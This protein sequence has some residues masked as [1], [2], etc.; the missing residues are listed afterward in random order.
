[1][2]DKNI[3]IQ[4][5]DKKAILTGTPVIVCGNSDYTLTFTF[6]NEWSEHN[7]KTARFS[8]IKEGERQ[9]TDIV[10]MGNIVTAPVLEKVAF[11]DVGV[12]AGNLRTTTPARILCW[13]SILCDSGVPHEPTP[14]VY[15]Q[16]MALLEEIKRVDEID[17]IYKNTQAIEE[18]QKES[19]DLSQN[20]AEADKVED[21][22]QQIEEIIEH[23]E[24]VVTFPSDGTGERGQFLVSNGDGTASWLTVDNAEGGAY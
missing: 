13:K 20:K 2:A 9:Y 11:V 3:K 23:T 21:L 14:D 4:V 24:G 12:F 17:Q 19:L 5:V 16:I 22:A 1:M 10:F 7:A 8:Y 6:D 18:L 15:A